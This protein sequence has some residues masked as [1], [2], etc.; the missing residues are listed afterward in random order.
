LIL[1]RPVLSKSGRSQIEFIRKD[2]KEV[3][4]GEIDK[5]EAMKQNIP[6]TRNGY[7]FI[8]QFDFCPR[9]SYFRNCYQMDR[10]KEGNLPCFLNEECFDELDKV[11]Q[12][13][14]D[15]IKAEAETSAAYPWG[16]AVDDISDDD[17]D[18]IEELCAGCADIESMFTAV[19]NVLGVNTQLSTNQ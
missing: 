15:F 13:I 19:N 5:G 12:A 11:M 6:Y 14:W 1:R 10:I 9:C 4:T 18:K 8:M 2:K 7:N 16:K 3:F 17:I